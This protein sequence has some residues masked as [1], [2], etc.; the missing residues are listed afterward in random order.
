ML[1]EPVRGKF[2]LSLGDGGILGSTG[3]EASHTL[4]ID[5]M[6][7]HNHINGEFKYL[8]RS[9]CGLTTYRTDSTCGEPDIVVPKEILPSGNN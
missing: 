8:L 7:S 6:P 5:E 4:T 9:N 2:I 3:G 1:Y